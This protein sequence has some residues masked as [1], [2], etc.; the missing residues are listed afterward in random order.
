MP[1]SYALKTTHTDASVTIVH[2]LRQQRKM[3]FLSH[4]Q[5]SES[6]LHYNQVSSWDEDDLLTI[7]TASLTHNFSRAIFFCFI[8]AD[9]TILLPMLL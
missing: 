9:D 7:T 3:M 5:L 8:L 1:K 2:K 6:G 4:T